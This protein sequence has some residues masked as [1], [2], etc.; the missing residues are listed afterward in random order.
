M[1]PLLWGKWSRTTVRFSFQSYNC[2]QKVGKEASREVFLSFLHPVLGKRQPSLFTETTSAKASIFG[3]P[4][5]LQSAWRIL[6]RHVLSKHKIVLA[7]PCREIPK[8]DG[9][10]RHWYLRKPL[11][12]NVW[13]IYDGEH[14]ASHFNLILYFSSANKFNLKFVWTG[15]K[16]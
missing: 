7:D 12:R 11:F 9:R 14:F 15:N 16:K 8:P 10:V 5:I 4:S 1:S 6:S 13:R 2:K 3:H